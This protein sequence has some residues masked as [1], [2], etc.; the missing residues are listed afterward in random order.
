M[1]LAQELTKEQRAFDE[2]Y[3]NSKNIP[4]SPG[5]PAPS[6]QET[7]DIM[8]DMA[9]DALENGGGDV[10]QQAVQQSKNPSQ[11]IGQ[12]ILQ[13]G[14]QIG[15]QVQGQGLSVDPGIMLSE[16]GFVEQVSD[17]VQEYYDI[18]K[19]IMD[20]AE[21]F[22]GAAAMQIQQAQSQGEQAPQ[23]AAPQGVPLAQVMGAV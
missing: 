10:L 19:N 5:Q 14:S 13:L 9:E 2:G 20:Q 1:A 8:V 3:Q 17:F 16:G 12:F 4:S 23:E 21:K 15:E 11:V 7:L 6:G 18:P 22:V